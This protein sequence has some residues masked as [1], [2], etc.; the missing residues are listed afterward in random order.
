MAGSPTQPSARDEMVMPSWVAARL[1]SRLPSAFSS[2]WAFVRSA[3]TSSITRLRRTATSEN[4]AA[5]K[6]PFAKTRTRTANRPPNSDIH[7]SSLL[8]PP[9]YLPAH[10][11]TGENSARLV[12]AE[13][14][15][16]HH[17]AMAMI[18]VDGIV[19]RTAVVPK[20]HRPGLPAEATG[21]F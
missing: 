20:G 21:E 4:S 3:A 10:G 7:R 17:A 6:K 8:L 9:L 1:A 16:M 19:H 14:D 11:G 13:R 18:V 5:T 12:A 15:A 2:A